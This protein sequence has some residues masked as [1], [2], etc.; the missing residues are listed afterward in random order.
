MAVFGF[1][2]SCV[3]AFLG[4]WGVERSRCDLVVLLIL[5]RLREKSRSGKAEA[6]RE[7]VRRWVES[8][9][10]PMIS[11]NNPRSLSIVRT[12]NLDKKDVRVVEIEV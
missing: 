1:G 8:G 3:E 12:L 2:C 5:T 6:R 10:L 4:V 11:R 7:L 9:I